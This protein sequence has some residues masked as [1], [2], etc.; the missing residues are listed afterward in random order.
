MSVIITDRL[1]V[2]STG[3]AKPDEVQPGV[4]PPLLKNHMDGPLYLILQ[5][6]ETH[7]VRD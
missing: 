7:H 3:T 5:A 2:S 1:Q 6:G 4:F